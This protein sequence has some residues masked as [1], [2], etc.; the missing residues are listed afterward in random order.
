VVKKTTYNI[1]IKFSLFD[2]SDLPEQPVNIIHEQYEEIPL[3][4]TQP[5]RGQ[6]WKRA[7]QDTDQ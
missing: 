5:E 7:T 3:L 2:S 6:K 1:D 4:H